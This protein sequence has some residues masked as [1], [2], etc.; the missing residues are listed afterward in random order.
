MAFIE[1]FKKFAFKGNVVD[2]A[3]GVVIGGAFQK[4][5]AGLVGNVFM[6]VVGLILPEGG[7]RE[8]SIVLRDNPDAKKVLKLTYGQMLGDVL[9]FLVVA[10]VLFLVVSRLI[11]MLTRHKEKEAAAPETPTKDQQL[12]AEIRDAL[13]ARQDAAPS[14]SAGPSAEQT[15]AAAVLS[16]P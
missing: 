9:D 4:I 15:A 7:W 3:V 16:K 14:A 2:L 8:A 5:V 10:F 12:L 6:P 11:P 13:R 1:E